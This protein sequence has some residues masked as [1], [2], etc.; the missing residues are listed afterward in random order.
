MASLGDKVTLNGG[1]CQGK[2]LLEMNKKGWKVIQVV[3]GLNRSF[4]MVMEK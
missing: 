1:K 4:G 3:T 2:T